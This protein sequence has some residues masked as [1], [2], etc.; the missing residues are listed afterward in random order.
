M[1]CTEPTESLKEDAA[2]DWPPPIIF[3]DLPGANIAAEVAGRLNAPL[4][5]RTGRGAAAY[6]GLSW[7]LVLDRELR[8]SHP[9]LR[10]RLVLDCAD[11][12][13][14]AL[15]A[16]RRR[17]DVRVDLTGAVLER[18][19]D[20]ARANGRLLDE[21]ARPALDLGSCAR[22]TPWTTE[23]LRTRCMSWLGASVPADHPTDRSR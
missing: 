2:A 13:G 12:T 21:D 23:Q 14:L 10:L 9:D 7:F 19:R 3:H 4:F 18:V 15:L 6:L 22:L 20:F 1:R 16:L 5:L 11:E 8:G 17:I